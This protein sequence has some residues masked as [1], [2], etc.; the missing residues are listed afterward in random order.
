M[1][2]EKHYIYMQAG[3]GGAGGSLSQSNKLTDV[4]LIRILNWSKCQNLGN[5]FRLNT[6]ISVIN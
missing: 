2:E 1:R 4:N 6:G 3:Q 5:K